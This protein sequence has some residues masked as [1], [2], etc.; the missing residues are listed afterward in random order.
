MATRPNMMRAMVV[1]APGGP[2]ALVPAELPVP[3][4]GPGEARIK[5]AFVGMNPLDAM[6]RRERLSWLPVS[7][8]FVPGTERSGI[9][10]AVGEGVDPQ[11]VGRRVLSRL[12]FGG[13]AEYSVAQAAS[14]IHL[15]D[16]MSL[17]LGA[18]YR[19][20]SAT[21]WYALHAGARVQAGDTVLVHSAAGAVGAMAM[22]IARDAGARVCGLAG[23]PAKVAFARELLGSAD[24]TVID[25]LREDWDT[26]AR[27][28]AGPGAF[29]VILDGNGG[30]RADLNYALVGV[31]GRVVYIGATAGAPAPPAPVA[32]LIARSFSVGGIDLRSVEAKLGNVANAIIHREVTGGRWRVPVTEVVPLAQVASLH[33]RLEARKVMGR[34]VIEVG[35]EGVA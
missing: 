20:C 16:G 29:D 21:A 22:Q 19:G 13:Y 12:G 23:G 3:A 31:L 25:Y 7:W 26:A 10:D 15:P 2:E 14:L 1:A 9:V 4:P 32:L 35:G 18:A 5:V 27:D 24:G 17:Q 8:P 30:S 6:A 33:A 11:L 28:F 34:A